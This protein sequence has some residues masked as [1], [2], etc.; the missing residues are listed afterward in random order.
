MSE[1]FTQLLLA[2]K[3]LFS[4][5]LFQLGKEAAETKRMHSKERTYCE[6]SAQMRE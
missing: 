4:R 6:T 5:L 1:A 3:M 2:D